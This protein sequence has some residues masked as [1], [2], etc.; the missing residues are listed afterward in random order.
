M[1]PL[2]LYIEQ[3]SFHGPQFSPPQHP[4][5]SIYPPSP[6][7]D[8]IFDLLQQPKLRKPQTN[9]ILIY[10]GSFNPPHRGHLHVLKHAFIRGTDGLNVIAAIITPRSD[11]SL[12]RKA[13]AEN[14]NFMFSVNERC[15]LW[16]SDL[17]FPPW[18]WVYNNGMNAFSEFSEQLIQA[19]KKDG[20]TLE[21]VPLY[22]AGAMTPLDP[23]SVY[24]YKTIILSDAARAAEYQYSSGR[25]KDFCGC[26]KWRGTRITEDKLQPNAQLKVDY[27]LKDRMS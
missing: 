19:A 14:G 15:H 10:P 11:T 8:P 7:D 17:G 5:V 2:A 20:Y 22:G 24:E 27:M 12:A 16:K 9:R 26:T 6:P 25:L 4:T 13:K 3:I 1:S 23:P 21:F 18:A